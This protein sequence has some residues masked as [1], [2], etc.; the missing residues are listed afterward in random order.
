[1]RK[2]KKSLL[3]EIESF[4]AFEKSEAYRKII[5]NAERMDY[6]KHL[7]LKNYPGYNAE[8]LKEKFTVKQIDISRHLVRNH[9]L[10]VRFHRYL[11]K[12]GLLPE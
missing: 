1:L 8:L 4:R 5:E 2:E 10:F 3:N 11:W 9:N 7:L 12:K 6:Q